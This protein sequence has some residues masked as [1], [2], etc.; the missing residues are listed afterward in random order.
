METLESMAAHEQVNTLARRRSSISRPEKV[1]SSPA[2]A[3]AGGKGWLGR[4]SVKKKGGNKGKVKGK[5]RAKLAGKSRGKC[6]AEAVEG[7][8]SLSASQRGGFKRRRITR[9][10]PKSRKRRPAGW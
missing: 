9:T 4:W 1:V 3:R 2:A 5:A 7:N 6:K 10:T 8:G